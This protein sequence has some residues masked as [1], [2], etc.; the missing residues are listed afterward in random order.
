MI[1]DHLAYVGRTLRRIV[2]TRRGGPIVKQQ[3]IQVVAGGAAL[4][5]G[6]IDREH[7]PVTD[8]DRGFGICSR[9]RKVDADGD[10]FVVGV[11]A[12]RSQHASGG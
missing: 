5:I 8:T 12:I 10:S 2:L 3:H 6:F 7:E 4:R 1:G 9:E 11:T